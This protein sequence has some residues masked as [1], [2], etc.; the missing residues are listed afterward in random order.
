VQRKEFRRS[1][2]KL[3]LF[4]RKNPVQRQNGRR[5]EQGRR[6]RLNHSSFSYERIQFRGK[7]AKRRVRPNLQ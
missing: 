4:L 7:G 3:L 6:V 2:T 1:Q 5:G